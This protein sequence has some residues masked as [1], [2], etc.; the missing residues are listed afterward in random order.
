MYLPAPFQ[1]ALPKD[2]FRAHSFLDKSEQGDRSSRKGKRVPKPEQ[3]ARPLRQ[4]RHET[5]DAEK[6]RGPQHPGET[7]NVIP[8]TRRTW[9]EGAHGHK[10]AEKGIVDGVRVHHHPP[11]LE[12]DQPNDHDKGARNHR[13]PSIEQERSDPDRKDQSQQS[14][15]NLDRRRSRPA[16]KPRR[17]HER[18]EK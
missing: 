5:N 17:R 14:S 12:Q 7:E 8:R 3:P 4:L 6:N 18:S 15:D 13:P 10:D 1:R 11:S 9:Q 2:C 16:I